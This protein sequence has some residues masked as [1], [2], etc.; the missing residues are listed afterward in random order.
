MPDLLNRKQAAKKL[1]ITENQLT[2]L[3][4]DGELHYINV[5]R[6]KKRQRMRFPE[7]DL[8]ELIE[9]RRKR[10]P[11]LSIN[12]KNPRH[13]IGSTSSSTVIGFTARRNAQLARKPR[14]SNL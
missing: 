14:N 12:R 1:D 10:E 5:G 13:I 2:G 9:R 3:V 7:A 6:G 4:L 11:C 8:N